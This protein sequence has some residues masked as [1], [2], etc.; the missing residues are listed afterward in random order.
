MDIS[1]SE[2]VQAISKGDIDAMIVW[3]PWATKAKE[4]LGT[5]AVSWPAQSGHSYYWLL[6]GTT[7]TI[8]KRYSAIRRVLAALASAEEF[9]KNRA[10]E[11]EHIM[12]V[13]MGSSHTSWKTHS[14]R[15][16]LTRSLVIEMEN[17]IQLM[18]PQRLSNMPNFLDYIHFD[19]LKSVNPR[20]V[21]ILY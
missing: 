16:E 13:H 10:D 20:K 14:F 17:Q 15:L 11:A 12:A 21:K 2:Q 19:A 8:E 1:P 18:D 3:Q 7:E 9:I 5:N 6:L 4:H